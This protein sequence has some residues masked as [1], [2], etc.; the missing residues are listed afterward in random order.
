MQSPNLGGSFSDSFISAFRQHELWKQ[1]QDPDL[2]EPYSHMKPTTINR[3]S[4]FF[5]GIQC[6]THLALIHPSYINE[7]NCPA[8][9]VNLPYLGYCGRRDIYSSMH[10][11]NLNN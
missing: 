7:L 2:A 1:Q 4:R 10:S 6:K 5:K 3:F 8:G 9:G 11:D